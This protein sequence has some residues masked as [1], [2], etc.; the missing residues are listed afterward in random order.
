M[1]TVPSRVARILSLGLAVKGGEVIALIGQS[2]TEDN[3]PH[4]HFELWHKGNPIN[5]EKYVVF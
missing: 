1:I 4:L 5:P 3:Q 2:E